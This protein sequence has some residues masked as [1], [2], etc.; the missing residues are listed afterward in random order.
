MKELEQIK[1][2]NQLIDNLIEVVGIDAV[3][4]RVYDEAKDRIL[5]D[6]EIERY[7]HR[8]RSGYGS[9]VCETIRTTH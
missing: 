4:N 5:L 3:I 1:E 8:E 2:I 6:I 9:G 7:E